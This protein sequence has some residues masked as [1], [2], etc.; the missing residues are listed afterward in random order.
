MKRKDIK[1]GVV[2]AEVSRFGPPSPVVFLEDGAATVWLEPHSLARRNTDPYIACGPAEK[3]NRGG[4]AGRSAGYAAVLGDAETLLEGLDATV[5]LE[6]FKTRRPP[7]REGLRFALVFSLAKIAGPYA[8]AVAAYEQEQAREAEAFRERARR[9]YEAEKRSDEA[10]AALRNLGFSAQSA[11]LDLVSI[12]IEDAERLI[13]VL[14]EAAA[15]A[16]G[17]TET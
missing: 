4:W 16:A 5:E 2:Y 13:A 10:I 14:R 17:E 7:S 9:T 15:T 12:T 1:A 8:E 3:P 11:G 6:A